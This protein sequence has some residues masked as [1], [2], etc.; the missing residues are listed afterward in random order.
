[1]HDAGARQAGR[2][3]IAMQQTVEQRTAPVTG[4]RMHDH[5]D[6][7]IDHQQ[8]VVFVQNIQYEGFRGKRQLFG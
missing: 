5:P 3:V 1:M 6:R 4:G 7:F 2:V 8:R